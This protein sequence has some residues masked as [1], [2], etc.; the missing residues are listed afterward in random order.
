MGGSVQ[1]RSQLRIRLLQTLVLR[2]DLIV[3]LTAA[4][5]VT[6]GL[7]EDQQMRGGDERCGHCLEI[8]P[9]PILPRPAG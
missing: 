3:N 8:A 2:F 7:L 9:I 6:A 1:K 5:R 4:G